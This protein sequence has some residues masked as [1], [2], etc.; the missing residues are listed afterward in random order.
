M[1]HGLI[2]LLPK[3][4]LRVNFAPLVPQLA[5]AVGCEPNIN[6]VEFPDYGTTLANIWSLHPVGQRAPNS[7]FVALISD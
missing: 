2:G 5:V 6:T 7:D 3:L 1:R 4:Y